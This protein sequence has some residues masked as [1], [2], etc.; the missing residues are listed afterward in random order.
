MIIRPAV[1][2]DAV[3]MSAALAAILDTWESG[4]PRSPGHVLSN[5]IDHPDRVECS[6]AMGRDGT[7]LGFQSLKRA[8]PGNPYDL[9]EGWGI[10]GT[11]VSVQA[12][13]RGVG[14]VLF[15]ASRD[16]ARG[17]GIAQID[18]TIGAT[19]EGALAYYAAMGFETYRRRPRAVCKRYDIIR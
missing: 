6:V 10:I 12:T 15:A 19:N 2:E 17:A 9:S 4:R 5:Y 11:Y 7:L 1:R 18:A 16:S 3:A 8:T 13:G 14:R